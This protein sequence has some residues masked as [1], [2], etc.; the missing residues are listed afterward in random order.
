M[1]ADF[2]NELRWKIYNGAFCIFGKTS[3]WRWMGPA[4]WR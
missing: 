4:I 1:K 3:L 2:W